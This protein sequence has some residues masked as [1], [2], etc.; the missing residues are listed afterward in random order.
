M[1]FRKEVPKKNNVCATLIVAALA[2]VGAITI[3]TKGKE[4]YS[5]LS[6]KFKSMINQLDC[7]CE[8]CQDC[9]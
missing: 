9:E 5:A 1:L 4:I 2:S 6:C 8:D 7:E 3:I